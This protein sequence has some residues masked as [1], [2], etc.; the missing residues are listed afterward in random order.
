MTTSPPTR[1][2]PRRPVP[3][4]L[5]DVR[6]PDSRG[7]ELVPHTADVGLLAC[8]GDLVGLFEEAAAAFSELTADLTE[9][10]PSGDR[11]TESVTLCAHDLISLAFN[12]LN[13]LV[14]VSELRR[15]AVTGAR[16]EC[17]DVAAE[18]AGTRLVATIDLVPFDGAAARRH[19]SVKSA[20]FYRLSVRQFESGWQMTAYL[21]V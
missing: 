2:R 21:D 12:W 16:V 3:P 18:G 4:R 6:P 13:E 9:D 11:A 5:A 19:T 1:R 10:V 15:S 20:T 7:H 17:V 14:T 8:A